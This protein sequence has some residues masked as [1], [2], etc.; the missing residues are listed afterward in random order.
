MYVVNSPSLLHSLE[1]SSKTIQFTPF[2]R[3]AAERL[4]NI[5]GRS[6][7]Q[8]DGSEKG[9]GLSVAEIKFTKHA[10][11]H[12]TEDLNLQMLA[13]LGDLLG[14]PL[15]DQGKPRKLFHWIKHAVTLA[16]T[17]AAYGPLNPFD[18]PKVEA[19]FR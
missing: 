12:S 3:I 13:P 17:K 11:L 10:I 1:R 7:E 8:F 18:D 14:E 4:S 9:E 15:Q 2:V 19:A 5:R 6:L 16:S